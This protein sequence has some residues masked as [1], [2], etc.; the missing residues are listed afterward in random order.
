MFVERRQYREDKP[1]GL[2]SAVCLWSLKLGED[3]LNFICVL[4]VN[5]TCESPG[6]FRCKNNYCIFSGLLCNQKDDCGDNSDEEEELCMTHTPTSQS[7][8]CIRAILNW[9]ISPY[10]IVYTYTIKYYKMICKYTCDTFK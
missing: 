10:L 5:V 4:P 8:L 7:V 3:G 2:I 9:N 6:R 1:T